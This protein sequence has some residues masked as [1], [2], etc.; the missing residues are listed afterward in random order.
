MSIV[1]VVDT[2]MA[3]VARYHE[4]R[5]EGMEHIPA[6]GPALIVVNHSLATYDSG[7]L[8]AAVRAKCGR[9]VRL[10]GDRYIFKI[11]LLRD[12]ASAYGF[13]EGSQDNAES[14]LRNGE[15]VL[16]A[17]G[18]MREALR[19]SSQKYTLEIGDRKGFARLAMRTGA[20]VILSACPAADD[21]Y[22]VVS[23]PVT[24]WVYKRYKLAVPVAFGALGTMVPK[25]AKLVH[26][27]NEPI[28]PP[29]NCADDDAEVVNSFHAQL[30]RRLQ[31]MLHDHSN[32]KHS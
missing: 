17:P 29:D 4:H 19:P 21:I 25:A 28:M 24:E 12:L 14:L 30:E 1:N 26:Y 3:R 5:V 23:S 6:S 2:I 32:D 27:I 11:P 31:R 18:G 10:L 20:P 9:D 8:A 16:V 7:L 13:I 22:H 15:L